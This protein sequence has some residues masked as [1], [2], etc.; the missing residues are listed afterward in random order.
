MRQGR[1]AV[2]HGQAKEDAAIDAFF[3]GKQTGFYVDVGAHDGTYLSNTRFFYD[4]G[5]RGINVEPNPTTF[6][7]LAASRPRDTNLNL[8]VADRNG[9]SAFYLTEPPF[10]S[11]FNRA[12]VDRQIAIGYVMRFVAA[13]VP[14]ATLAAILDQHVPAGKTVDFISIDTEGAERLVLAGNDW[15]RWKPR[16]LVVEYAV[17]GRD[18]TREWEPLVLR[19]GYRRRGVVGC[20]VFYAL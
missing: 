18:T 12:D 15:S 7:S 20:N 19:Q 3:R 11:T 13:T 5:W 9:E 8:A 4:R 14:V 17:S 2:H 1:S 6:K 10:L 16:L